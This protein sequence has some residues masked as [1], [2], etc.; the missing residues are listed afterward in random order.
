LSNKNL[1]DQ[2]AQSMLSIFKFM[3]PDSEQ[4]V[5]AS[6][7]AELIDALLQHAPA[8]IH[9]LAQ[10]QVWQF[11]QASSQ[12]MNIQVSAWLHDKSEDSQA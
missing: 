9:V 10:E 2:L 6:K 1:L 11:A 3:V 4:P 8:G 12:D 5:R 7:L